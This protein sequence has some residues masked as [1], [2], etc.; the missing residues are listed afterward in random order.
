MMASSSRLKQGE[1]GEISA[2]IATINKSG[3][4]NE[5]ID[6]TSNDPLRPKVRLI[7]QATVV[8]NLLPIDQDN[9]CK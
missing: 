3:V 2:R 4:I 8:D 5:T 6:V 9:I 1:K 7:L